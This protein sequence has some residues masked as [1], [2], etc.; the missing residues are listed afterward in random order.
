M[1]PI[2]LLVNSESADEESK[3]LVDLGFGVTKGD[4]ERGTDDAVLIIQ[5]IPENWFILE[6]VDM[7]EGKHLVIADPDKS[8]KLRI[9]PFDNKFFYQP[10]S[11]WFSVMLSRAEEDTLSGLKSLNLS[12]VP[13]ASDGVSSVYMVPL[14]A[15]W[16]TKKEDGGSLT[17][18]DSEK[19]PRVKLTPAVAG[20]TLY[21]PVVLEKKN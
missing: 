10:I 2:Q 20:G 6:S 7:P 17:L 4:H 13:A 18:R 8:L 21:T 19:K 12:I 11:E 15:R 9:I 1:K 16:T 3:T 14:P 5:A